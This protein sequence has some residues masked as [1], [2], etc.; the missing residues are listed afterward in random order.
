MMDVFN[1]GWA[2]CLDESMSIWHNMYTCPGWIFCP[3]KPHPFGNEYHTACCALSG[4]LFAMEL[5]EGKDRPKELPKPEYDNLGKTTGLL[6]RMLKSYFAT[7]KYVILDSGFCVL[8]GLVELRKRGL[9]AGALI[10]KRRFWPSLVPGQAIDEHCAANLQVGQCKA[11]QGKLDEVD[12]FLWCLRE[13]GYTMKIMATG[14]ALFTDESCRGTMREWEGNSSEFQYTL[15]FDWHFRF[16]HAIDDHNNLRHKLPSVEDSWITDR[17]PSRVFSFIL[18]VC[19]VNAFLMLRFF[20]FAGKKDTGCPTLV[21]FRRRLGWL[22]VLNQWIVSDELED[23][24][25]VLGRQHKLVRAPAGAKTYR[26]RKWILACKYKYQQHKCTVCKVKRI[27]TCCACT[28]GV[29]MCSDCHPKHVIES[30]T[31]E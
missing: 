21:T 25:A 15:P 28:L 27:R 12:Y 11:V 17:W 20:C 10:K 4:I 19:E 8:K 9:F 31:G 7:G 6:L 23:S 22:L 18:A 29:W 3:R 5:V 2:I 26:N 1:S 13:P 30:H 14:G 16:R 24:P